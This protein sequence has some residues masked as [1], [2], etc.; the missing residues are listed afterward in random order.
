MGGILK[1]LSWH[2]VLKRQNSLWSSVLAALND[3]ISDKTSW[4]RSKQTWTGARISS[5]SQYKLFY[6]GTD[7]ARENTC[8]QREFLNSEDIGYCEPC[9]IIWSRGSQHTFCKTSEP[10]WCSEYCGTL[11]GELIYISQFTQLVELVYSATNLSWLPK[12][13]KNGEDQCQ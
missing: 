3:R 1:L 4:I 5:E 12:F 6:H 7:T 8:L 11:R 13:C 9:R 10:V 2:L